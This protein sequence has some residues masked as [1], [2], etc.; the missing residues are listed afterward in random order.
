VSFAGVALGRLYSNLE[1]LVAA[2]TS[3]LQKALDALWGEM[4]LARKIQEALVP[5]APKLLNCEIAATMKPADDVGGDYYDVVQAGGR[6]W[7][8]IGDV[9]GHGV[10]AGL[11]MMMC[12]TAVRTVLRGD[13]DIMPDRLLSRVNSV[14]TENI[15]QLGEDKYMT[16]SAFRSERDGTVLYAGAHQ[17]IQIYRART[18]DVE[19]LETSGVWLGIKDD[20]SSALSTSRFRLEPGD[21]LLLHTDGVTEAIK[22]GKMFDIHGL[23]RVLGGARDRSA[24]QVLSDVFGALEGYRVTDDATVLTVRHLH[25]AVAAEV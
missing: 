18:D 13:P 19:T 8:L 15:R 1:R 17:D 20:I 14:L 6:D 4:K 7:I 25:G 12:H 16:I 10:P 24:G 21:V 2:R 11:V 9:S 23:R 22:D 3:E 5:R